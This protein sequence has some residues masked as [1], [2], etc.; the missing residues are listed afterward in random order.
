M[1]PMTMREPSIAARHSSSINN[2]ILIPF[3]IRKRHLFPL[4]CPNYLTHCCIP[5]SRFSLSLSPPFP[6]KVAIN[7]ISLMA[8]MTLSEGL[9][10]GMWARACVATAARIVRVVRYVLQIQTGPLGHMTMGLLSGD[11][12][13]RI[14]LGKTRHASLLLTVRL[15]SAKSLYSRGCREISD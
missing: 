2:S 7:V 5:A 15:P 11:V 10:T 14:S 3:S 8:L 12:R 6:P 1:T 13:A 9:A 4:C